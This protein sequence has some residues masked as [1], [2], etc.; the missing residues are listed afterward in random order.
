MRTTISKIIILLTLI[1]GLLASSLVANVYA[2]T[3]PDGKRAVVD[4]PGT[5][6]WQAVRRNDQAVNSQ[7]KAADGGAP[8]YTDGMAW[9]KFRRDQL[10]PK[11]GYALGGFLLV[12]FLFWLIRRGIPIPGGESGKG[13]QRTVVYERVVHWTMTIV[14]MILTITG[15]IVLYGR[16]LLIPLLGPENYGLVAA[17]SKTLH[18]LF[19]IIFPLTVMLMFIQ[20]VGRNFYEKGDMKWLIKGGGIATDAHLSAGFFNMGEKILFWLVML[21]GLLM[22]VSGLLINYPVFDLIRAD[23]ILLYK[24]HGVVAGGFVILICGHI[25]LAVFGVKGTLQSMTHGSVDENWAKSHHDRWYED[26]KSKNKSND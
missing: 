11:F 14:F 24:V 21:L 20:F 18:N 10:M 22:S 19:G 6:F 9:L 2:Q 16:D 3:S 4:A 25:Y 15:F 17:A 1:T 13:M 23:M 5:D 26:V 7:V 12:I 8:I